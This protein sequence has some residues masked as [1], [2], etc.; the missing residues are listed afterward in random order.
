[1][2]AFACPSI[3]CTALTLAPA[4]TAKLAAVCRRSCGVIA[5]N[6]SSA[7]RHFAT[8]GA[9]TLEGLGYGYL[10]PAWQVNDAAWVAC[11]VWEAPGATY[12]DAVAVVDGRGYSHDE[13]E[14]IVEAAIHNLCG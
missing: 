10:D 6:D 11:R 13:A 9:N 12:Y 3:R 14:G 5:G 4:D 7:L 1:M 2:D 8:A